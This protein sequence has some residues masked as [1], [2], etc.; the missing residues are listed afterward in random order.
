MA[1]GSGPLGTK[2]QKPQPNPGPASQPYWDACRRHELRIQRCRSCG[3]LVHY[4]KLRCPRQGCGGSEFDWPLMSGKGTVYSF[5][6]AERAFHPA[7]MPELPYVVAVIELAEGP[8]LMSSVV[9]VPPHDVRIGMEVEVVWDDAGTYPLPKFR[10][11]GAG[12]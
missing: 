7:F 8:R 1:V 10:P 2:P 5:V 12:A 3:D 9:G 11:I 6:V 4:P